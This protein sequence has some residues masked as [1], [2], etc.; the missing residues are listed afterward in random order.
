M[1]TAV[2][3]S[4]RMLG[5][6]ASRMAV[7]LRASQTT[8]AVALPRNLLAM[9]SMRMGRCMSSDAKYAHALETTKVIQET[10]NNILYNVPTI[11]EEKERH[12]FSV[13][14]ENEP[15]VLAKVSGLLAARGF[16]ID[17]LVVS[18]TDIPQLS[19]MTIVL[20]GQ[21][22]K[23]QQA[24]KQLEDLVHVYAVLDYTNTHLVE[25]ELLLV[26]V[27]TRNK[28]L[29]GDLIAEHLHRQAIVELTKL[30]DGRVVDIGSEHLIIELTSW[31][32]RIDAFIKLMKPYGII[33][34]TRSGV[35]VQPRSPVGALQ[36]NKHEET[37]ASPAVDETALPPG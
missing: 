21:E 27:S 22:T 3:I 5:L 28:G 9:Q 33:E 17:S 20:R 18:A 25:R 4:A 34:A 19:R 31:S 36:H 26:K 29:P 7:T 35:M 2:G 15:G 12:I 32:R 16:N 1:A 6:A 14:V 23:M 30:F 8:A 37:K 24:R 13:L 11:R 10:V